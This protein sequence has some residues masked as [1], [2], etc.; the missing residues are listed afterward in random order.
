MDL[1]QCSAHVVCQE[2][3]SKY[4]RLYMSRRLVP[5]TDLGP[6]SLGGAADHMA[7]RRLA[8]FQ[9]DLP[10]EC[11]SLN[12]LS[13]SADIVLILNISRLKIFFSTQKV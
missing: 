6:C 4:L 3:D 11:W 9:K 5:A 13:L 12:F 2:P 7:V 1:V 10:C 8:V